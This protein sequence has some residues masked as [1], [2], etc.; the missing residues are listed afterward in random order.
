M[1]FENRPSLRILPSHARGKI[2]VVGLGEDDLVDVRQIGRRLE[3]A[4]HRTVAQIVDGDVVVV[5]VFDGFGMLKQREG[6]FDDRSN[7]IDHG[8]QM[9]EHVEVE[10]ARQ[11][12]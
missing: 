11:G 3:D 9:S 6:H 2:A 1:T 12:G 7:L 5:D 10:F 4:L 8:D